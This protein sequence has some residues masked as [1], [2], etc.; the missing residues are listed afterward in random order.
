[1]TDAE[2]RYEAAQDM[3]ARI[4]EEWDRLGCPLTTEGG[5]TGRAVVP[6]PL[7]KMLAEA[8]RDCDRFERAIKASH[9]G[10]APSAV[11][12]ADIGVSPAAK[13]R[14]VR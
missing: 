10:P 5:A 14:A 13:L 12:A 8:E 7:V 4:R 2:I 6:H 11:V 3:S 1:M 9:R